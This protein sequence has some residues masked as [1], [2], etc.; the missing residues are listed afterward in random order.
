M[1]VIAAFFG[2]QTGSERDGT[3][4]TASGISKSVTIGLCAL[5]ILPLRPIAAFADQAHQ[6]SAA[7]DEQKREWNWTWDASAFVGWNY[8]QRKFTDFQTIESQNWAMGALT[9]DVRTGRLHLTGMISLEPF[10]MKKIGSPQVFQTG[11]TYQQAP[12]IDYQHPH[13]LFMHASAAYSTRLGPLTARLEAALVGAPPVGPEV[14]M[15]R[16]S[17]ADNPQAPLGHHQLDATHITHGVLAG[18]LERAG[19]GFDAAWF[20]GAEPDENR[21]D[22]D[23]GALDSW[24]VR[25]RAMRGGWSMQVSGAHLTTPEWIEPFSDV[26]RLTAS[27]AFTSRD[28]RLAAL[29]AWGQNREVHGILDAYLIE[30]SAG[31]R[32]TTRV[33]SRIE[34]VAKNILGAGGRH[35]PGVSHF[36]PISR[37][38][39]ATLGV[40]RDLQA[41][42]SNRLGIGADV[43]VYGVPPDL[44]PSH[45]APVSVHVFVHYRRD[46]TPH[47]H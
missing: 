29:V 28:E 43:T 37:I 46:G 47:L 36:H 31:V 3:T 12:L 41:A 10:T 40:S 39:A 30:G 26:T 13:D 35:L 7:G 20:Q 45:G 9:R 6:H 2:H 19:I 44:K 32:P 38:V 21:T 11:E 14:F 27:L 22:L 17:A 8:Q 34:L 18:G 15:H 42:R 25:A 23:L 33:Y 1:P 24:A 4:K 5:L 16:P